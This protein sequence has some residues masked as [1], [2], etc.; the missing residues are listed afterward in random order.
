[1]SSWPYI[2]GPCV[3]PPDDELDDIQKR[4]H[5]E[6]AAEDAYFETRACRD[7]LADAAEDIWL[8]SRGLEA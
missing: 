7:E 1:M 2:G 8:R 6:D 3:E 5:E 4:Q